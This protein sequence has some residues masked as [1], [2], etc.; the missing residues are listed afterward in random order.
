MNCRIGSLVKVLA[1]LCRTLGRTTSSAW[2][3]SEREMSLTFRSAPRR[4]RPRV[5]RNSADE[6]S[7][8]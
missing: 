2:E 5:A 6:A 7:T 8:F 4:P 1:E 3:N